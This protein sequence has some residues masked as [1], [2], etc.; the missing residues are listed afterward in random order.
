MTTFLILLWYIVSGLVQALLLRREGY[1]QGIYFLWAVLIWP[2]LLVWS[3]FEPKTLNWAG[4][5]DSLL[6]LVLWTLSMAG[7][8]TLN[9]FTHLNPL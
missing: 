3:T 7:L 4:Y 8:F 2:V 6:F 1:A 9:F 5:E